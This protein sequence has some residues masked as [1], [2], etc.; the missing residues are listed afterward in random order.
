MVRGGGGRSGVKGR[1]VKSQISTLLSPH[2]P[3]GSPFRSTRSMQLSNSRT[4][5]GRQRRGE[6]EGERTGGR[7]WSRGQPIPPAIFLICISF[8][9]PISVLQQISI[10][11]TLTLLGHLSTRRRGRET[12]SVRCLSPSPENVMVENTVMKDKE[13]GER[14]REKNT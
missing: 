5:P 13:K 3:S 2:F 7:G 6:G 10:A 9:R 4:F 1:G 11:L 14:E 12:F 8:H